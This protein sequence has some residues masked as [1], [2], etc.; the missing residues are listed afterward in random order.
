[1]TKS[2]FRETVGNKMTQDTS[3]QAVT[4]L[5]GDSLAMHLRT[6]WE[7]QLSTY[8]SSPTLAENN[9]K[10]VLWQIGLEH[11]SHFRMPK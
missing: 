8:L 3:A 5:L 4:Q 2:F 9:G 10:V 1:M 11:V 6:Y 7:F